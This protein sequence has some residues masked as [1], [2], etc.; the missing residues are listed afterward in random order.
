MSFDL[1][2]SIEVLSRTPAALEALLGGLSDRW[3]DADEG[4]ETFSSRDV[5]GHL[6]F[7]EETDWVPRIRLILST[8]EEVPFEPFDRF[9][10]RKEIEGRS[11]ADLL[12]ELA[13]L[14]DENLLYLRS[15]ALTP[16]DLARKGRHPALGP[17][18]LDQLIASWV[19]HDL[20]HIRQ[21]VRVVA[22]QYEEAV[23]PW[24]EYLSILDRPRAPESR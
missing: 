20:G 19:V 14:R 18:T 23:G 4:P 22:H 12:A 11:M 17:V 5:V 13:R 8:G 3:L 16:K 21:I 2:F 6:I 15:L 9:G 1:D 24:K 7:G 10:F